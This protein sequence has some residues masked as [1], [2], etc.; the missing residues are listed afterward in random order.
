MGIAIT[1]TNNKRKSLLKAKII[2]N[3]DFDEELINSFNLNSKAL[4]IQLNKEIYIK[5]K[6]FNGINILGLSNNI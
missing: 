4:V 3:M 2:I 5:S 6:L 1:I